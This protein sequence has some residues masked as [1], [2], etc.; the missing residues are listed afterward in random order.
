MGRDKNLEDGYYH[1]IK[2][3]NNSTRR[4]RVS[5]NNSTEQIK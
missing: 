1:M 4:K 2:V 3:S 5:N